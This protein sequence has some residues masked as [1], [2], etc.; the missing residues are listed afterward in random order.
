M[1]LIRSK[2]LITALSLFLAGFLP[3]AVTAVKNTSSRL[4]EKEIKSVVGVFVSM[5]KGSAVGS[6]VIISPD[7]L[8]VTCAHVVSDPKITNITVM[9]YNGDSE[10]GIRSKAKILVID[11]RLDIAVLQIQGNSRHLHYS[12]FGDS[13]KLRRGDAVT[14]IGFPLW[15]PWTVTSG[16]ISG[17]RPTAGWIQTD[18]AINPGNSGGPLFNSKGEVI[19][20]NARL[21]GAMPFISNWSGTGFAICSN[22]IKSLLNFVDINLG[23]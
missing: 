17:F 22:K 10:D 4:V 12:K 6:G 2:Y 18:A 7:G 16:S 19:G 1:S 9:S 14:A 20:I 21:T 3:T 11:R 13:D 23:E 5:P 15:L 8:V